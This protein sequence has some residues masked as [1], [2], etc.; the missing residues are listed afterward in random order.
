MT[1]YN[2]LLS[3][4]SICILLALATSC[5]GVSSKTEDKRPS[6]SIDRMKV[7]A[8][9]ARSYCESKNMSTDFC[10]LIDM[11]LH[12]GVKRFFVWDFKKDTVKYSFLVSHGSCDNPW[13]NDYSKDSP[14]FSNRDGSHCSSLGR[15]KIGERAYSD[16]GVHIKYLLH[17]L[18][19]T[20]SNALKRTIVLHSWE[21]VSDDEVYPDG[22]PEG[23]GCPCLSIK[24]F[25]TVDS[26]I[27]SASQPVMMWI[28]NGAKDN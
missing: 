12:S 27:K 18:D 23:W 5:S 21:S 9:S 20:N 22:T 2:R 13:N 24:S 19:N 7:R 3:G 17:G 14:Q 10:I 11:S 1:S 8:A 16:W 25:T 4:S 28:Y 26:L 6:V 15:Y